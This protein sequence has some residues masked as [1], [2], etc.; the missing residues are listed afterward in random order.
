[1]T[2]G[3]ATFGLKVRSAGVRR[4]RWLRRPV[5]K[6]HIV[7]PEALIQCSLTVDG[8]QRE[9]VKLLISRDLNPEGKSV[10]IHAPHYSLEAAVAAEEM[11]IRVTRNN[12]ELVHVIDDVKP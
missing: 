4:V 11:T 10:I 12:D 2:R 1:M 3:P 7:T 8:K 6:L 5:T 9:A